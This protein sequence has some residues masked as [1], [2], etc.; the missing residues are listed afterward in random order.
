MRIQVTE[1]AITPGKAEATREEILE[2]DSRITQEKTLGTI[3]EIREK[4]GK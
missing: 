4:K 3:E 2:I 1:I